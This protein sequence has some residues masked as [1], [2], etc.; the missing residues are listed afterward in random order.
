MVNAAGDV[1]DELMAAIQSA[2]PINRRS[3]LKLTGLSGGG[4]A[5]AMYLPEGAADDLAPTAKG[6]A[7]LNA[8][9][10]LGADGRVTIYAGNPD[11][12]QGV[13]TSMPMVAAEELGVKWSDVTVH[14]APINRALYGEQRAGG[15]TTTPRCFDQMRRVGA[16]AREMLIAAG[17]IALSVPASVCKTVDSHVVHTSSG[18]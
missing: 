5:L 4:F 16:A 12:G 15:S 10:R 3:F 18:R 9:I 11:M 1:T 6:S 13:K 7:Q 2:R 14:Q 8:F 17:S